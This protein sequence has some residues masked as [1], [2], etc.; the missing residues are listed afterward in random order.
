MKSSKNFFQFSIINEFIHNMLVKFNR[1]G[2]FYFISLEN[3]PK[4]I[5]GGLQPANIFFNSP[6]RLH[7]PQ[8]IGSKRQIRERIRD[9]TSRNK[10]DCGGFWLRIYS[11][12]S[13]ASVFCLNN[14]LT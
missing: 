4:V 10:Y 14:L 13:T 11:N 2:R 9:E 5:E 7:D 3:I 1:N 6:R 8:T 12:D